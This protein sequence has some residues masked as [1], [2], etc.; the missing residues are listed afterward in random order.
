MLKNKKI[1]A[2]LVFN[3]GLIIGFMLALGIE[4]NYQLQYSWV[5]ISTVFLGVIILGITIAWVISRTINQSIRLAVDLANEIAAGNL[6]NVIQFQRQDEIGQLLQALATMQTQLRERIE[7]VEEARLEAQEKE[8]YWQTLVEEALIGLALFQ[9]DGRLVNA[10][11]T[12]LNMIGNTAA[13][14][15]NQLTVWSLSPQQ[16]EDTA[17]QTQMQYLATYGR[18]GPLEKEYRHKDGQ[19]VLIQESGLLIDRQGESFIWANVADITVSKRLA[20]TLHKTETHLQVAL[21]IAQMGTW[22]W[23]LSTNEEQWS[24]ETYQ[25]IG[26]P[27][28]TPMTH[29]T[30][31]TII[32]P[33]DREAVGQLIEQA[34]SKQQSYQAEFRLIRPDGGIRCVQSF[35]KPIRDSLDNELVVIGTVQDITT[36]NRL[37]ETLR[38]SEQRYRQLY[39]MLRDGFATTNLQGLILQFNPAFQQ[40]VGYSEAELY[41]LHYQDITSPKWHDMEE[42][43]I[44]E[45]VLTRGYSDLYEQEYIRPDGSVFPVEIRTYLMTTAEGKPVGMSAFVRDITER[46]WAQDR[47]HEANAY[48]R[49]LIE[50]SLD[51]LVTITPEGKISDLNT[52]TELMTGYLEQE[53][54]GSYFADYFTHPDQAMLISQRV[55][56]QNTIHDYELEIQ[57]RDGHVIAVLCN[58]SVYRDQAGKVIGIFAAARDITRQKQVEL[59]LRHAKEV[60]EVANRAKSNFLANMSHELRT[61]LNA[62]LGYTQILNR[63]K[64]LTPKQRE[65]IAII[66]RSGEYLLTLINDVLDLSKI[67]AGRLELHPTDFHLGEFIQGINELVQL[68]AQQKGITYKYDALAPLPV[69][70]YAD[71]KRL[72]QILL[73]LL[74]NAIKFTDHGEVSLKLSYYNGKMLFQVEDTGIGI[75]PEDQQKIFLPFQQVG[76][77]HYQAEG[78]GLGLSIT[79]KLVELMGGTL[80]LDSLPD[81]G[82]VF[83][84]TLDLPSSQ[85]I[86]S[87]PTD[88]LIIIGFQGPPRRILVI[89]DQAE[90]L[91]MITDLLTPLGFDIVETND[92]REGLN[93]VVSLQPDLILLD[94]LMPVMNGFELTSQIRRN[95]KIPHLPIIAMSA[96]VFEQYQQQSLEVGCDD[97]LAKPIHAR[98]LFNLLQKH[99][100]LEWIYEVAEVQEFSSSGVQEYQSEEELMGPT[101]AQAAILYDLAFGDEL[102][103]VVDQADQFASLDAT[104]V[105]FANQVRQL[106]KE[107]KEEQLCELIG[108]YVKSG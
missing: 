44:K 88:L 42:R 106:A 64:T 83:W 27:E 34:I 24:A 95:P 104:L 48:Y 77:H 68:R 86:E 102:S 60:A 90:N 70:I 98:I 8:Q 75:K 31:R 57:H 30:F 13:E 28:N 50:A 61:P 103:K 74:S 65:G 94:L 41:T 14:A 16:T 26:L 84:T 33:E 53:L 105:P 101:A 43:I 96:S 73:N 85:R 92:G 17:V 29:E 20:R 54:V 7:T 5:G 79:K 47:L 93:L 76:E 23:N 62:I 97:F 36:R 10:N 19:V 38:E 35:G 58:A 1:S 72:R 89:D 87:L 46:K 6:N 3:L 18:Y 63:D 99:L 66:H 25:I 71:D 21:K 81:V 82:S 107:F 39:D 59:E 4:A 56:Y 40:L 49:S 108:R 91:S 11:S 55:L 22:E 51:P 52:A 78:T 15:F 45:Q 9:L 100:K 2:L 69:G 37:E 67:E 12:Y 80:Q 32:H